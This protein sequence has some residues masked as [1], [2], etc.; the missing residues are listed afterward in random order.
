M[1]PIDSFLT[2]LRQNPRVLFD[3]AFCKQSASDLL[4]YGQD[5]SGVLT[6]RPS[7][8]LFPKSTIEVSEILKAAQQFQIA[9]V[10]SGGRTGL[11]GG[12]VAT[13]GEVV[14]STLKLNK[15]GKIEP[16]ALSLHVGA[17]AITQAVHDFCAPLG[18]TW[19]VDFASKGS[20]TVGGNLATNAGGIRVLKYGN[21]R[22]W[23]LG[24][25]VVTS[26]GTIHEFNHDLEK[27]N[28][29]FDLRHLMIGSEGTLGVIT[30]ATL[31]L[32]PLPKTKTAFLFSLANMKAVLELFSKFRNRIPNLS[33][34]EYFDKNCFE[35]VLAHLGGKP[36]FQL[37]AAEVET[38]EAF[39]LMEVENASFEDSQTWLG[40]VFEQNLVLDG[41]MAES[42]RDYE[43]FWKYREGIAEA[44]LANSTVHQED[45]SVPIPELNAFFESA[46][47]RYQKALR[48]TETGTRVYFFG[49]I[50]DGNLHI[51]IQK[52][53]NE[54]ATDFHA[55]MKQADLQLFEILKR[56]RGSVSAEHGIGLLKKHAIGFSRTPAELKLMTSLKQVFDPNDLINPGKIFS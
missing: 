42:D 29:G 35:A 11:S 47:D 53:A 1:N 21:T 32:C 38:A 50:G 20:S 8:I 6:P 26:D 51:F 12:A 24:M 52:P 40:E 22:N 27:N 18:L 39:V 17:G 55:R 36:P 10:P 37:D 41:L 14:V 5:W 25:T 31:K 34:F 3:E 46:H 56:H 2:H 7:A 16:S 49:H 45:V 9:I 44:I 4:F 15:I 19:P 23:V 54:N 43:Q 48:T 30:E 28:T 33:A 13:Q